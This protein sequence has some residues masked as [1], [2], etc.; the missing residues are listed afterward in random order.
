MGE[1]LEAIVDAFDPGVPIAAAQTPPS[2]WY[3]A[4]EILALER[5]SVFR[6]NWVAVGRA[7]EVAGPGQFVS[8]NLLGE[9]YVI[10][11]GQDGVLRAFDN[12]CRHHATTLVKGSGCIDRLQCPYH[13]WVYDLEG[14]LVGAPKMGGAVGFDRATMGLLPRH[15]GTWG[16]LLFLYLGADPSDLQEVMAPLAERLGETIWDGLTWSGREDH[17]VASNWKVYVDNYLDGGYHVPTLHKGLTSDLDMSSYTTE[18]LEIASI[19]A[20][21]GAKGQDRVGEGAQYAW[22]YPNLMINRYGGVLD[23]NIVLPISPTRTLVRFDYWFEETEG[24]A[25]QRF[26]SESRAMSR[27]VQDEDAEICAS[28]QEGLTSSGYDTGRYAPTI[29]QGEHHFHC[30]LSQDYREAMS[31][32]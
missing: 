14:Q 29:E 20:V 24:A 19:Q 31:A 22:V 21:G 7:D 8:G 12:V 28:V 30:L 9:P 25:A 1:T 27:K 13:G 4:S 23:V 11:R 16:P 2:A 6:D 3:T 32:D 10:V 26:M 18:I 17:P 5:R 15:T